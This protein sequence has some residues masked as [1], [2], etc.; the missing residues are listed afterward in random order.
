MARLLR[1]R[2]VQLGSLFTLRGCRLPCLRCV[3]V[4]GLL[5]MLPSA[6]AAQPDE[7]TS[8]IPRMPWGDPDLQGIWLYQTSTPLE[9]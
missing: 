8:A 5:L 3:T 2:A 9:P 6:T 7:G 1:R 4:V